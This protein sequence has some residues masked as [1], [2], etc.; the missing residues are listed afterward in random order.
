[1]DEEES[2]RMLRNEG[3]PAE[4]CKL[5]IVMEMGRNLEDVAFG[6]CESSK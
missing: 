3:N 5:R 4:W 1:M 2:V 6:S